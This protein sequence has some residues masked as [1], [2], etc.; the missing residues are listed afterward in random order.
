M[1][2]EAGGRKRPRE[3]V[4]V[5][6]GL[7]RLLMAANIL[8][9]A[10]MSADKPQVAG[11]SAPAELPETT[12]PQPEGYAYGMRGSHPLSAS[13]ISSLDISRDAAGDQTAC[14]TVC[15]GPQYGAT[16]P[17]RNGYAGCTLRDALAGGF[18]EDMD[19]A[20]VVI[21]WKDRQGT[22][23]AADNLVDG[24]TLWRSQSAWWDWAQPDS[25]EAACVR[26]PLG[27]DAV[28]L[29]VLVVYTDVLYA[30]S[31]RIGPEDGPAIMASWDAQRTNGRWRIAPRNDMGLGCYPDMELEPKV[32]V[33]REIEE[34]I[35]TRTGGRYGLQR[36]FNV[37]HQHPADQ[38]RQIEFDT[39]YDIVPT[40]LGT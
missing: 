10:G 11:V 8:L 5:R 20:Q 14:I 28:E 37:G 38:S 19:S 35:E 15:K 3:E 31:D 24:P 33:I 29:T 18:F 25:Q 13:V 32:Q 22:M 30:Y 17:D 6:P 23:F 39:G 26:F 40:P 16:D 1:P 27:K 21:C 7:W 34:Q 36:R 2:T 9:I 12:D 4:I